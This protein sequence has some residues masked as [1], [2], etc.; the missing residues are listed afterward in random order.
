MRT[1]APTNNDRETE[2][3]I[4]ERIARNCE[5][6]IQLEDCIARDMG[7]LCVLI[8]ERQLKKKDDQ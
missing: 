7:R 1:Y 6:I 8:A 3:E 4:R 2:E 5:N